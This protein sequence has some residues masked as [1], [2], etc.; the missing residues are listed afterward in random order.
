MVFERNPAR[1]SFP[2]A[3]AAALCALAVLFTPGTAAHA[4]PG[5]T[6]ALPVRD[7]LAALPV[8]DEDRS[9]YE[10]DRLRH[11]TE[12]DRD[13]CSTR[14]EVLLAEAVTAPEQGAGCALTGGL[15]YSPYGDTY[16]TAARGLDIDP[17]P[18][19]PGRP[20]TAAPT[21]PTGWRSKPGGA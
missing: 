14:A 6:V 19:S 11:W 21:P 7:A 18:G 10:R 8:R 9:G 20:A 16:F 15:W 13:G 5:D 12:A 2:L 3:A 1:A 17:P 4:D